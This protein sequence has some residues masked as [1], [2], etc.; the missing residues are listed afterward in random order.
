MLPVALGYWR[1]LGRFV[2]GT[3][4]GALHRHGFLDAGGIYF[5]AAPC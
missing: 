4:R 3:R 2:E 1:E 5:E